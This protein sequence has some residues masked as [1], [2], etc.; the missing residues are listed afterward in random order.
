MHNNEKLYMRRWFVSFV[1][2][3]RLLRVSFSP[4]LALKKVHKL[5]KIRN[6]AVTFAGEKKISHIIVI[7]VQLTQ[8]CVSD[9][10]GRG[11]WCVG[12]FRFATSLSFIAWYTMET[13]IA[14]DLVSLSLLERTLCLPVVCEA[15]NRTHTRAEHRFFLRVIDSL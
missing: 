13:S 4:A 3:L 9:W 12:G 2:K 14:S 15:T 5:L 11:E 7:V 8:E 10:R 6:F 1:N